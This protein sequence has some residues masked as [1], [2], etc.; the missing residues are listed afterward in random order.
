M[1]V[2]YPRIVEKERT[3]DGK[4]STGKEIDEICPYVLSCS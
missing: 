1:E 4:R 3:L 2:N